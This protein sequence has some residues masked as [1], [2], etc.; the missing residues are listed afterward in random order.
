LAQLVF[1]DP[2][3]LT[4]FEMNYEGEDRWQTIGMIGR[5]LI[6]VSH[7][8]AGGGQPGRIISARLATRRE[9]KTYEEG[10]F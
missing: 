2:L 4:R 8:A 6:I 7:T 9:R 3:G 1:D 5:A 10:D